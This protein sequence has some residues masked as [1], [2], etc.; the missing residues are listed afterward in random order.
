VGATNLIG[1]DAAG[2][3]QPGLGVEFGAGFSFPMSEQFTVSPG[4]RFVQRR[5]K[6]NTFHPVSGEGH[7]NYWS[8]PLELRYFPQHPDIRPFA[9]FGPEL[10]LLSGSSSDEVLE[11]DFG[12]NFGGGIVLKDKL[13]LQLKYYL[14]MVAIDESR[15]HLDLR[16]SGL[17]SNVVVL[18]DL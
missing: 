4:L 12:F 7:V 2:N 11:A 18:M 17:M 16:N 13:M 14:G 1:D 3:N 10:G 8:L 15:H 6:T 5:F 9:L